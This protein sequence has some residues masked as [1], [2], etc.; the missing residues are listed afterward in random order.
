VPPSAETPA[1][2]GDGKTFYLV[3]FGPAGAEQPVLEGTQITAS[4]SQEQVTGNAG[5]NNYSG[6]LTPVDDYFTIGPM[7]STQ[8][9]CA[10]PEGVMEQEQAYLAAL[11][12]TNGYQWVQQEVANTTLVSAGQLSYT[13]PD[14]TSGVMNFASSP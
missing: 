7:I 1:A 10:E 9:F 13:L 5:C 12:G 8:M 2:E 3:S 4:F 14:G 6:S 11:Q